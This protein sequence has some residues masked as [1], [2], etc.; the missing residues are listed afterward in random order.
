[1]KPA[2]LYVSYDGVLEPL[3]ESQVVNYLERLA[4]DFA[5]TLLSF[6]KSHDLADA[7]R[8]AGMT[9]RL[10]ARGLEW[11]PLAYHKRPAVLSTAFD[12]IAG[13]V[14][15]RRIA[16]ARGIRIIHARSYVPALIA[17]GARRQRCGVSVR[18]ARLLG[19]RK[20]RGRA[21]DQRRHV[22]PRR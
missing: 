8:V 11:V 10:M 1:V 15:A 14:R 4:D 5:I 20:S 13:I 19:R 16:R 3:G 12:A 2:V 7:K 9:T 18:H 22:V 21:L 6:E 17:L